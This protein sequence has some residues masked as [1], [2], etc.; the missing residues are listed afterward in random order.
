MKAK[1]VQAN[2]PQ[3]GHSMHLLLDYSLGDQDYYEDCSNC[4]HPMR[5]SL[6]VDEVN[7]KLVYK[8]GADDE[9]YY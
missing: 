2:C 1:S 9:Q 5:I 7:K 4:C 6:H 8:I 3:C